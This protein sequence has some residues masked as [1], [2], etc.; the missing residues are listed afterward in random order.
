MI[1]GAAP[2][3]GGGDAVADQPLVQRQIWELALLDARAGEA[4]RPGLRDAAWAPAAVSAVRLGRWGRA[5]LPG[6]PWRWCRAAIGLGVG[7]RV[8][9]LGGDAEELLQMLAGDQAPPADLDV[10]QVAAA[11]LVV[12]QVAGQ[13]GQAGG[14]INGVGQPPA[15][16]S[17]PAWRPGGVVAGRRRILRYAGQAGWSRFGRA[18]DGAGWSLSR[19]GSGRSLSRSCCWRGLTGWDAWLIASAPVRPSS[20]A[21]ALD[22]GP[23]L[24]ALVQAGFAGEV[25][26]GHGV[27]GHWK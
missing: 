22:E 1:D 8:A 5:V 9:G 7:H 19:L 16:G 15:G 6:A 11:H 25:G 21:P 4:S 3:V 24:V 18:A 12:E 26:E 14:L 13:A 10:G 20:A 2:G 27:P 17:W 23:K